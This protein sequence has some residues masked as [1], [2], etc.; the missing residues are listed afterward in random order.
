V[1]RHQV[2]D[3]PDLVRGGVRDQAVEVGHGPEQRVD[4]AVVADVV[5]AVGQR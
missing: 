2:D 1:V 4:R 5:T 3:D